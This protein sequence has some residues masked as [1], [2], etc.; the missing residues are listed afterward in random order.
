MTVR[1]EKQGKVWTIIHSR[2]EAKNAM[3]PESSQALEAAFV[4]F[5]RDP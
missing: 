3:D 2:A 5:D 4:S 1:I